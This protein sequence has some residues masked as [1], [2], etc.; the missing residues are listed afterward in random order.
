MGVDTVTVYAFSIE[1]FKRPRAE[2]AMLMSLFKEK[3][4]ELCRKR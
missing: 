2:V 4:E 1:N 3:L